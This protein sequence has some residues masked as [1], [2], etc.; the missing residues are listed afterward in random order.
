MSSFDWKSLVKSIAPMLGTALGGPLGGI[1]GAALSKALGTPDAE[2][3]TLAAAVQGAT[4]DQLAAIQKAD[5]DFKVQMTKLGFENEEALTRIAAE[6]R[7][8]AR[9]REVKTG[10]SW[11]PRILAAFVV[12]AWIGVQF[13]LL[14]HIVDPAMRDIIMR[15]LGTLD[16]ALTF[17]LAYYFGSSA[18]SARKDEIIGGK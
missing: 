6:D 12:L 1:A 2:P 5:Q 14:K 8:S 18:G 15:M 16:A 9:D 17:V 7:S 4:P 3:A 13:F 10:D 11:T